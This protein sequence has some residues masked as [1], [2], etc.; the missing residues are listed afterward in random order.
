MQTSLDTEEAATAEHEDEDINDYSDNGDEESVDDTPVIYEEFYEGESVDGLKHG[1]GKFQY[2]N[3]DV[4]EGE[5]KNDKKHG[6]GKFTEPDETTLTGNW[7][8]DEMHCELGIFI[9]PGRFTY[10][11]PFVNGQR[12]GKM[13]FSHF[14]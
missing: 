10:E 13:A 2:S 7:V 5:W 4:F 14:V 12:N 8:D 1:Q 11:G 9:I 6:H 3:G